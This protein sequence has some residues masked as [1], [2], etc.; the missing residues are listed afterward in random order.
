MPEIIF[1]GS[2]QN[3]WQ[4][5]HT[6]NNALASQAGGLKSSYFRHW[7]IANVIAVQI[8]FE[9]ICSNETF[10]KKKHH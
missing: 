3:A 6:S 2:L 5:T 4:R 1:P 10:I 9:S 8:I 7:Q